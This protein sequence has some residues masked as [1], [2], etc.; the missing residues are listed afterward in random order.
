VRKEKKYFWVAQIFN[1]GSQKFQLKISHRILYLAVLVR[2]N[3]A[4]P[5]L[6]RVN[7]KKLPPH[8]ST[9]CAPLRP[10]LPL[11]QQEYPLCLLGH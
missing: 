3:R 4:A 9:A 5:Y 8:T 6:S 1:H 2:A 10:D 7:E 11:S